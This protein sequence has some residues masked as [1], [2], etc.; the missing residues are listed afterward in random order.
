MQRGSKRGFTLVE[1]LVV[2]AIITILIAILLPFV[3]RA[4]RQALVLACPISFVGA[5]HAVYLAS[6]NGTQIEVACKSAYSSAGILGHAPWSPNGLSLA[7]GHQH[8]MAVLNPASGNIAL[9]RN[10]TA[11]PFGTPFAR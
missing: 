9:A 2:I 3:A 10:R 8:W 1:L 6:P 4:R 11:I 7:M 5:D